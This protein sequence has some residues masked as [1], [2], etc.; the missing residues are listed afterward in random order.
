[1][2][3]RLILFL[4]LLLA[5]IPHTYAVECLTVFPSGWR[6]NTPANEQ[7]INFP[8]N[9]S[10]NTLTDGTILPRGDNLY[11]NSTI[12]NQGEIFVGAVT[13]TE[14]T[15]RLFFRSSVSWH[16]VKINESGDPENLIIVVDSSL[17]ISGDDTV[18]NA[19]IYVKGATAISGNGIIN[20]AI[21]TVG[22]ASNFSVNYSASNIINA[23]FNGMCA[24]PA[25]P[26]AEYRFDESEYSDTPNEIID[27]I[28]GFNG[29]A[30][31]SQPIDEGVVCNAIDLYATGTSDYATLPKEI[32]NG[33]TDFS[34]SLWAK[35]AKTSNQSLLS[36]AGASNNELIMWFTRDTNF[37]PYLKDA[38]NGSITTPSIADDNWHHLVWTREGSQSCLFVDKLLMSC[39]TQTT[40]PLSIQSLVIGQEQDSIGGSFD[41][42]QTF[43][44]LIDELLVFN[45][46]ISL[47]DVTSIHD[48]QAAGLGYDG[49]ARTC[50]ISVFP[51]PVLDLHFDE[52]S[53]NAS[54]AIIDISGNEY[55]GNAVNVVP[56][57]STDGAICRAADL[58]ASGIDD[59]ITL[60]SGALNNRNNFSISMWYKTSKTG[61]QSVISGSSATS[62]NE[63]IFWFNNGN[64]F[65]PFIKSST[66]PIITSSI[67]DDDWH[68]VVWTRS[69]T[70]NVFYRDGVLQAGSA[71]LPSGFVEITS[72]ILGQEQDSLGGTFDTAQA[73]EGLVDELLIFGKALTPTQVSTVYNNQSSGLNFDAT[74]R[75][76]PLLP[77]PILNMQFDEPSWSGDVDEVIDETG[78]FNS[79]SVNGANTANLTPAIANNPGTCGYGTFDG[80]NDYVA[81]PHSFENQQGSFT[82]TAWIKPTNSN[83]GSRIFADDENNGQQGYSLSLGDPGSGKLRFYSRGVNP[84]SVDTLDSVIPTDTWTFVAAVHNSEA[85]TRQIYVNGVAQTVTGGGTSNIYTGTWGVDTGRATIGGESDLGETGNR[86]TGAI[87]EVR[88]YQSALTNAE[89]NDIQNETHQCAIIDHFEISHDGQGLTCQPEAITIKACADASCAN[90]YIGPADVALSINGNLEKIVTVTGGS[91]STSFSYIDSINPA[92]LSLD[93]PYQCKNGGSTSCDVV[94][95][96]AGFVLDINGANDVESCDATKSLLI[97]AVKLSNNG[98]SCAPAFVGNQSLNFVFD[99]QNPNTGTVVPTLGGVNM[100]QSG[101]NQTKNV[102]FDGNGE[103]SLPIQYNDAGELQFSVSE[104]VPSGVTTGVI[105]KVFY[106]TQLA[107][108]TPLTSTDSNGSVTQIAGENFPISIIAQCQNGTPTN[109]YEPQSNNTLQLS[110]QQKEPIA[111]KGILALSSTNINA[112]NQAP[113]ATAQFS[114]ANEVALNFNGSYSEVGIINLAAKDT[115]YMGNEISSAGFNTAGRFTPDRFEV[116]ITSNSFANTCINL[117]TTDFTYI[118]QPFSYLNPPELLITAKNTAGVTTKNYTEGNYQKLTFDDVDRTFPTADTSKDGLDLTDNSVDDAP[119]M[120]IIANVFSDSAMLVSLNSGEMTY[121]FKSTDNFIF[122]KNANSQV[123]PF[124]MDYTIVIDSIKD[125]DDVDASIALAAKNKVSPTGV[126][127]RFGRWIIDNTF[128]PETSN[129]PVPMAIQYWNGSDFI[130]NTLD[131][132]T[133]YTATKLSVNDTNL[134]PG[135]TIASGSGVF[136]DGVASGV[137]L[138]AP[139]TPYQGAVPISYLIPAMPWLQYD[140]VWDGVSGREFNENPSA[141]ATFGQFR[142]NDRIIYQREVNN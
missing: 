59:Y 121:T 73:V 72:L 123:G 137:T 7:L 82:I 27:S 68:H 108:S 42:A 122:T 1:M 113:L 107:V 56:T 36:G 63:L 55:H 15:A 50:P 124:Q 66:K 119:K 96:E 87:D 51:E 67:S 80:I 109:N 25:V 114:S 95:A 76:C 75:V 85:K 131:N 30:K 139:G 52:T 97:K 58:S 83:S 34:I 84:V 54:N 14:T 98:V 134:N 6:Q 38:A 41:S 44:G 26:I 70:K 94:F 127:L 103:A 77:E 140:W 60:N 106:P 37:Y 24:L 17:Q 21:T 141:I 105:Q 142:G 48:Y 125:S 136:V 39:V 100:G 45:E 112:T 90:L 69:S 4:C 33:K 92:T 138:S 28:G 10:G 2:I 88:M 91:I 29:Q 129:L 89:I 79:Q 23:D 12:S 49:T 3:N 99:Y 13:G 74:S 71:T 9:T 104:V 135:T 65:G 64:Q 132:C 40:L 115:N 8:T 18:I 22:S 46:A 20:G 111:N 93:K 62:F 61:N 130:T 11:S 19:I 110:V 53:W 133:A 32:L 117:G 81:L 43:D 47:A 101:V 102:T 35:T 78:N 116:S 5:V 128:G 86:F 31:D 120:A 118:G 16:N 126:N 57:L